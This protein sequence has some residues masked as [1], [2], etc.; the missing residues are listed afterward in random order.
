MFGARSEHQGDLEQF[1]QHCQPGAFLPPRGCQHLPLHPLE[2]RGQGQTDK[3]QVEKGILRGTTGHS[4]C[5]KPRGRDPRRAQ[6]KPGSTGDTWE[7]WCQ[8]PESSGQF[9]T[10]GCSPSSREE[11][12]LSL[13]FQK[14]EDRRHATRAEWYQVNLVFV[15]F[16]TPESPKFKPLPQQLG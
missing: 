16:G 6:G 5:V 7:S 8:F 10:L 11:C 15:F 4:S 2:H 14:Q 12:V 3:S 9:Q 1:F 13:F